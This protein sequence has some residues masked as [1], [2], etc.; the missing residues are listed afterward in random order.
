MSVTFRFINSS[1]P[2]E[3]ELC[4]IKQSPDGLFN[5]EYHYKT[6]K[7]TA[8][9]NMVTLTGDDVVQWVQNA[10]EMLERDSE[11]LSSFQIDFPLLPSIIFNINDIGRHYSA[12]LNAVEFTVVNWPTKKEKEKVG[13][14]TRSQIRRQHLFV[15]EAGLV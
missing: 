10:L 1:T 2:G 9:T 4:C 6:K 8:A 5:L 13:V 11:P 12:I 14:T 3:D 15:D 7:E